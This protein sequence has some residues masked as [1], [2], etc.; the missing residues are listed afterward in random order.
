M[1]ITGSQGSRIYARKW[2][3]WL[4]TSV[5]V[6]G[7]WAVP[8]ICICVACSCH[9]LLFCV[10]TAA[11]Y[12]QAKDRDSV[13]CLKTWQISAE[14]GAQAFIVFIRITVIAVQSWPL[15]AFVCAVNERSNE[16]QTSLHGYISKSVWIPHGNR[17]GMLSFIPVTSGDAIA[18]LSW[19]SSINEQTGACFILTESQSDHICIS[20]SLLVQEYLY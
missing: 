12:K 14:T 10:S 18:F 9:C 16:M 17:V 8:L 13:R 3:H 19:N 20:S 2:L 11:H 6:K 1:Y 5:C 15:S 7:H 4:L